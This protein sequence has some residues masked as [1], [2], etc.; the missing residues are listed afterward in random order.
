MVLEE[1]EGGRRKES[2]E[3]AM[4]SAVI[5]TARPQNTKGN[6]LPLPQFTSKGIKKEIMSIFYNE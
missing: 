4:S 5:T 3:Q 2:G 1:R 6:T